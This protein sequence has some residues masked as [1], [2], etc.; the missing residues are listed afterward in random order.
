[1]GDAKGGT[2]GWEMPSE[3]NDNTSAKLYT[4]LHEKDCCLLPV[5]SRVAKLYIGEKVNLK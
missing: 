3:K 5:S 4:F 1:M 2:G